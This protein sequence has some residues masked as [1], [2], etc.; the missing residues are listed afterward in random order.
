LSLPG[1]DVFTFK[2]TDMTMCQYIR[3]HITTAIF[4]K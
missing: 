3:K 4:K 2:F 1:L